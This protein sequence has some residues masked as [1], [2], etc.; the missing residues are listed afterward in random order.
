MPSADGDH[1]DIIALEFPNKLQSEGVMFD[2]NEIDIQTLD[3]MDSCG[4]NST[5]IL[6]IFLIVLRLVL[7]KVKYQK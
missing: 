3:F 1:A 6:K 2:Q 4:S 7:S 5:I